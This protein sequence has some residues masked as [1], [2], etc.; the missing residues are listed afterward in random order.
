MHNVML[1]TRYVFTCILCKY[2]NYLIIVS[3]KVKVI[4]NSR[5]VYNFRERLQL[6][7][8]NKLQIIFIFVHNS[9]DQVDRTYHY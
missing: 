1:G 2:F 6:L 5:A 9:H 3:H 7:L 4:V 8:F